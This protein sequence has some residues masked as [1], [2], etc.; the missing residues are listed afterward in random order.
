MAQM[1]DPSFMV[2]YLLKGVWNMSR[3][4]FSFP[5][6]L[7]YWLFCI[8]VILGLAGCA[9]K[10]PDMMTGEDLQQCDDTAAAIKTQFTFAVSPFELKYYPWMITPPEAEISS[11]LSGAIFPSGEVVDISFTQPAPDPN[12]VNRVLNVYVSPIS[13]VSITEIKHPLWSFYGG[14]V[15]ADYPVA[16][17]YSWTPSSSGKFVL[18]VF[19]RNLKNGGDP[20]GLPHHDYGPPSVAYVCVK[21]D[22]PK[23][24]VNKTMGL[25]TMMPLQNITL[26]PTETSTV[27]LFPSNTVTL[28]FTPTFTPTF[29]STFTPTLLPPVIISPTFTPTTVAAAACSSYTTMDACLSHNK[30]KWEIPPT[31]GPGSCVKK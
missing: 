21:I 14:G 12:V 27:T 16:F 30:C 4:R 1:V 24:G 15:P 31:G 22:N 25:V 17:D 23:V 13:K 11:P 8:T 26:P 10:I 20:E 18:L 3:R 6:R 9:P 2:E 29:T 7:V 5:V 19:F 28:T